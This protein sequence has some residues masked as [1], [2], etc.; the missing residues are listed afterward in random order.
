M[1]AVIHCLVKT[2][3]KVLCSRQTC[4]IRVWDR[5][6]LLY[7]SKLQRQLERVAGLLG[8]T[9]RGRTQM[10]FQ[11][12][13]YRRGKGEGVLQRRRYYLKGYMGII[14]ENSVSN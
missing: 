1:C 11:N 10:H 12:K 7:T 4:D 3:Y 5:V 9:E 13:L 8:T 2:F 14:L 6:C